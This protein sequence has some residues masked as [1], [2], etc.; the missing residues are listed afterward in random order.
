MADKKDKKPAP[1]P[2]ASS[3]GQLIFIALVAIIVLF[4]VAPTVIKFFGYSTQNLI[5][6]DAGQKVGYAF[7]SFVEGLSFISF[8]ISFVIILLIFY[9]KIQ[10]K[11][12]TAVYK[13]TLKN[14]EALLQRDGSVGTVSGG[15]EVV[16]QSGIV[17]P[18][19]AIPQVVPAEPDPRWI[20]IMRHMDSHNQSDWRIAI[21][22][23]DILLFDMLSQMGYAGDSI[24]DMLK[25]VEPQSFATLDDAWKAH[26]IR[27][28]IAH[29]GAGYELTRG[30]AERAIR[31]Y[32]RVFEEF[33]F[34]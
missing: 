4:I 13:E 8:F 15:G 5:P 10:Y 17:L 34:I 3:E 22:E 19:S 11:E 7:D 25:Q 1:K 18:G 2:S 32:Q 6:Q 16:P 28:T 14:K 24:G 30:E 23:A 26:R 31:M 12:I 9:A 21:L 20:E 33:Y 29:E 27:N